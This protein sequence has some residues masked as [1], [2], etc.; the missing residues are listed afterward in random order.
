MEN[1]TPHPHKSFIDWICSSYPHPRFRIQAEKHHEI[2]ASRCLDI[3]T[4]S[5]LHFNMADIETSDHP[6][7]RYLGENDDFSLLDE[8]IPQQVQYA[9]R[10]VLYHLC[11]TQNL[12]TIVL[13]EVETLF[14]NSLLAWMEVISMIRGS[15]HI[16]DALQLS[17]DTFIPVRLHPHHLYLHEY[18]ICLDSTTAIFFSE[19]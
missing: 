16:Y 4:K 18:L 9:C 19:S 8:T 15:H 7:G 14:K 11:N 17:L 13:D 12:P 10:T 6:S 3:L 1:T 5:S 2:M